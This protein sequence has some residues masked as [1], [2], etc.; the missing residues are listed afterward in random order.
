MSVL[1][2]VFKYFSASLSCLPQLLTTCFFLKLKLCVLKFTSLWEINYTVMTNYLC[3]LIWARPLY[4]V[5][6]IKIISFLASQHRS[7]E[8]LIILHKQNEMTVG[9]IW[10]MCIQD[11]GL[12]IYLMNKF[13]EREIGRKCH[14]HIGL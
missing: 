14:K 2:L 5:N 8:N 9:P 12:R 7:R 1:V 10:Q 3:L 11:Y 4:T 13:R 6:I